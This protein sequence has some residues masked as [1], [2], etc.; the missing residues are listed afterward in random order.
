[1]RLWTLLPSKSLQLAAT[2]AAIEAV[3]P[4]T[5]ALRAEWLAVVSFNQ[6]HFPRY[7]AE[8]A[9]LRWGI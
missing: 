1:M 7:P 4:Q 3:G 2:P 6:F 5:E 8:R 9:A